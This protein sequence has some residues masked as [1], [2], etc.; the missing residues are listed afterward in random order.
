LLAG[1]A[2]RDL[3]IRPVRVEDADE[4][5]AIRRHP[6]VMDFILSLPSERAAQS[7][8][9]I[10]GLGP[11]DHLMVAVVDGRVAGMA[12][13]HVASGKRRHAASLG[14]SVHRDYHGRGIGRA[15][16]AC[17]LDIADNYLGLVRVELEVFA[18]NERAIAL[19]ESLGF[20]H[21]GRKRKDAW[22]AGAYV[23]VLVMARIRT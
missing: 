4:L 17:L 10:E 6:E 23:D 13:L 8:R 9:F 5:N 2:V 15:L 21:E 7:R 14:I 16:M 1:S 20:E 11:D 18:D 19:Y 3:E 12:G 22:R